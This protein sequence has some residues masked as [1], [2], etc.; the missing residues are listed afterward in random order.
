MTAATQV[1]APGLTSLIGSESFP[2]LQ[3]VEALLPEES[4]LSPDGLGETLNAAHFQQLQTLKLRL[5]LERQ[6]KF[7]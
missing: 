2:L 3:A 5:Q 7:E 4:D 1:E 6:K